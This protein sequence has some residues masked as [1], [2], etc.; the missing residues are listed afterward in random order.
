MRPSSDGGVGHGG[1]SPQSQDDADAD[2]GRGEQP[3]G[4]GVA[5]GRWL[6]DHPL[7]VAGDEVGEDLLVGTPFGDLPGDDLPHVPRLFGEGD[8]ATA[9]VWQTGQR[10]R[11]AI[12]SARSAGGGGAAKGTKAIERRLR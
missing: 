1:V 2:G 9:T 7:S 11:E 6:D 4:Q 3:N 5:P 12:P 8:S 10:R